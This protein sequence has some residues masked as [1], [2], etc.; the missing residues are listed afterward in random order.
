MGRTVND[1]VI[2]CLWWPTVKY[3][4]ATVTEQKKHAHY[5]T[6]MNIVVMLQRP[7]LGITPLNELPVLVAGCIAVK[8]VD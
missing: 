4:K 3:F 7:R 2:Y 1:I 5:S 6:F 8:E